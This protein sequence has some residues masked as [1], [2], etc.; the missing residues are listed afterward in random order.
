MAYLYAIAVASFADT[1]FLTGYFLYGAGVAA[2]AS[3]ALLSGVSPLYV[4][5]STFIGALV[6]D[7]VNYFCGRIFKDTSKVQKALKRIEKSERLSKVVYTPND[8]FLK[9]CLLALAFRFVSLSRPINAVLLGTSAKRAVT[10]IFPL[11]IA[12]FIWSGVWLIA[13][14]LLRYTFL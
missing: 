12:A 9:R 6:G 8:S 11:C 5:V 2:V 3:A 13:F 14:E 10:D 4:L 7:I 1:F